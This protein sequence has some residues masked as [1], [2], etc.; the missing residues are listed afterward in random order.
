MKKTFE[1]GLVLSKLAD[2][3]KDAIEELY[4][5]YY[6]RLHNFSK[7]FLKIEEGIDDILQEV[8]IKICKTGKK[9]KH[10]IHLMLLFLP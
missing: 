7:T 9:S 8:F 10:R 2:G 5:Y 1:M 4:N 6:P 3:D